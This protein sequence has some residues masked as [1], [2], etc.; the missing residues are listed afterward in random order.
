M[1]AVRYDSGL[2]TSMSGGDTVRAA[3]RGL[4]HS[5]RY[6]LTVND[7]IMLEMHGVLKSYGIDAVRIRQVHNSGNGRK[8]VND[9]GLTGRNHDDFN[10][11]IDYLD[12]HAVVAS[13][14]VDH[15]YSGQVFDLSD[16]SVFENVARF[17]SSRD[18][19]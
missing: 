12:D 2:T 14:S 13:C 6:D 10:V 11:W 19:R 16:P 8:H 5:L 7:L 3:A 17:L 15:R 9:S 4:L 1:D 18:D